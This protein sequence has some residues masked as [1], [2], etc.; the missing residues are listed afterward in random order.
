[1]TEI[2]VPKI[3]LHR[4]KSAMQ[5]KRTLKMKPKPHGDPKNLESKAELDFAG[6]KDRKNPTTKSGKPTDLA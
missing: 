2:Q 3:R 6:S 1:M 4:M 5:L